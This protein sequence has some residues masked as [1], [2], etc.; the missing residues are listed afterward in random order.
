MV[1]DHAHLLLHISY[2][3][4]P[5]S[6]VTPGRTRLLKAFYFETWQVFTSLHHLEGSLFTL[7][8]VH[9]VPLV[10]GT[11]SNTAALPIQKISYS[12]YLIHITSRAC[13]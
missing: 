1:T 4:L 5:H 11:I 2:R 3:S 7:S 6:Y 10:E 13:V 12:V 9:S 8:L